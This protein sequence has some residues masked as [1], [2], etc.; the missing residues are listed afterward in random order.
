MKVK[1][2]LRMI[3]VFMALL[4]LLLTGCGKADQKK[5]LSEDK[6]SSQETVYMRADYSDKVLDRSAVD[7]KFAVYFLGSDVMYS[8]YSYTQKGGDSVLLIAPDGTTMLYDCFKPI[9]TAYVVYALQ[10]LGIEKIDYFVNSHP[11]VDHM[12]GFSLISRY[13]DI[14]HIYFPGAK[15]IYENPEKEG[16]SVAAMM[17]EIKEKKIPYSYLVE[18]DSFQF[19]SDIDVKVYN[20]PADMD[21]ENIDGNEWSLLLKFIYKDSTVLLGGDLGNNAAK[22]GRASETEL[23]AKYGSE[24]QADVSKCNHHGDGNVNG[25]TQAGSKDWIQTVNSKIYV[26][27]NSQFT[28]EK[29]YFMHT[30]SGAAVYH[31]GLDGS[32]L[33]YTSGDGVYEVQLE[34]ERNNPDY[35]GSTDAKDGHVTVK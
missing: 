25:N 9:S 1:K 20:P 35:F 15:D 14:G 32:V 18:G 8:S 27:C 13:F 28:D 19:T 6:E 34:M 26:A 31:T 10:Q 11:H 33:V 24:L 21:F 16:G 2:C 17:D 5:N 23:V 12:G 30:S 4:L 22:L 3:S 7:G 29:N